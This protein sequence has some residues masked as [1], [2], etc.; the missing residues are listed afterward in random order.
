MAPSLADLRDRVALSRCRPIGQP[1][2]WLIERAGPDE[3]DLVD[4]VAGPLRADGRARCGRPARRRSRRPRIAARRSNSSVANRHVR[5]WPSAVRRTRSQ[6]PQNG[7]VTRRDHADRA[8][9]V[10]VAPAVGRRRA[11]GRHLLERVHG[12]DRGDDLVL[13]DDLVV[14]PS[15]P[16]ASSG[17]NSMKRTSTPALAAERGEVDDLVVVD[18]ALDDGV[19]LHRV[20]AGLLGGLDAVEHVV[21]L[22]A[23]GHLAGTSLA[24]ERVEADVDPAQPG[25]AQLAR[26]RAAASPPLVVIA[27]SIGPCGGAQGGELGDEHREVGPDGRLA[28][29]EADAVDAVALDD[30]SGRG[31]RSPRTSAPRCAAATAC[32][33][34]ACSTCSGSCSG[35]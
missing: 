13:A 29:G 9:A 16:S 20:E 22:V 5:N 23:A 25:V 6:S 32:P 19:D 8:A 17:M 24:I 15:R 4:L 10:E 31:A 14:R 7:L 12:V 3:V 33:P 30:R 35:R 18:A 28:A 1:P 21:E 26:R 2:I 11:A 34:R 27:R